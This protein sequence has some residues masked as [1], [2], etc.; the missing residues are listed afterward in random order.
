MGE[1]RRMT[2]QEKYADWLKK[3]AEQRNMSEEEAEKTALARIVRKDFFGENPM[4]MD[5][6]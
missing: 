3:F 2:V 4:E 5:G 6:R 1:L